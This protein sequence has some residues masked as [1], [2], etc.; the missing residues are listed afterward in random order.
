LANPIT[1]EVQFIFL[2]KSKYEIE[3]KLNYRRKS[4]IKSEL[5]ISFHFFQ[6]PGK[7]SKLKKKKIVNYINNPSSW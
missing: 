4:R 1:K 5:W 2:T 3:V 7:M 6:L